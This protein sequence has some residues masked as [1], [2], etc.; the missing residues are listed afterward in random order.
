MVIT[1][2][3]FKTNIGRYLMMA[4]R[5]DITITKNGKSIAKLTNAKDSKLSAIHAMRGI[6]KEKDITIEKIRAGRL[7]KYDETV[8]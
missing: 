3:E 8:D 7:T 4:D 6:L 5:E 2:T 1:A